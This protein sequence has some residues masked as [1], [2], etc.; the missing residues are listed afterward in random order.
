MEGTYQ[1]MDKNNVYL[2][3]DIFVISFNSNIYKLIENCNA[4]P[5]SFAY[6]LYI[7]CIY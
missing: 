1:V 6:S 3:T 5:S 4:M 2:S 7:I